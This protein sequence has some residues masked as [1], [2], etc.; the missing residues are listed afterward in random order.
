VTADYGYVCP[1]PDSDGQAVDVLYGGNGGW[2]IL[3]D[4]EAGP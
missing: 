1:V 2:L 4:P 3:P